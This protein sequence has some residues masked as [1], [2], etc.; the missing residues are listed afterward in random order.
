M[1]MS[2]ESAL[3][4]ESSK[5]AL[6]RYV[7]GARVTTFSIGGPIDFLCEP[8]D[9]QQL[10]AVLKILNS[11]D[12]TPLVL[13]AGSNLVIS[14]AGIAS[15][16]IR[17][18]G[19]FKGIRELGKGCFRVG[20]ATALMW[21]SREMCALGWSG[22]EFAGGI[23]A[24]IG[25]AARMNAGAHGGAM[26]DILERIFCIDSCGVQHEFPASELTFS[27]R[28]TSL[29]AEMLI[30][31]VDLKLVESSKETALARR[32]ECLEQRKRTQ[33]LTEPS[34]G[35]VF[36]NPDFLAAGAAQSAGAL[37]EQCG[38]KGTQ[39]GGAEISGLHAN[40]IVN[41][42]KL[43]S[44]EDVKNLVALCQAKVLEKFGVR[45]TPEI[46]FWD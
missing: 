40:W 37:I 12:Q 4:A 39:C 36:R 7:P 46:I 15:P 5:I 30:T 10:S 25:G 33:P 6:R 24:T 1:P 27:Y 42:G 43:A 28:R 45:M 35:S 11:I 32:A 23:P 34:A 19:S 31:A 17:L 14:S 13:G 38:L 26:A 20:A 9:D 22:L 18:R 2:L 16:V 21:L 8:A 29:P 3:S 44:S 41:S